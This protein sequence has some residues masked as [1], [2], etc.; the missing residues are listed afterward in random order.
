MKSLIAV[1]IAVCVGS[2]AEGAGA[3]DRPPALPTQDVTV[4]YVLETAN[5]VGQPPT[6]YLKIRFDAAGRQFRIEIQNQPGFI[7]VAPH[8]GKVFV[9]NAQRKTYVVQP[10]RPASYATLVLNDGIRAIRHDDDDVVDGLACHIWELQAGRMAGTACI[11]QDGVILRSEGGDTDGDADDYHYR[12]LA[13]A[14]EFG[15]QP[16]DMFRIPAK[17]Q[18]VERR[19]PAD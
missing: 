1:C 14:I 13:K 3:D 2:L 6:E 17:F 9:V 8:D 16:A 10:Y 7:I 4:D 12:L 5:Q 18:K 11:T 19:T 15:H